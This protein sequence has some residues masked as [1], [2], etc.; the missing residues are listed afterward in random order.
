MAPAACRYN[1]SAMPPLGAH[2]SVA[3]GLARAF[4]RGEDLGCEAIQIFVKN[5]SQWRAAPLD[6][7]AAAQ[8]RS[9]HAA[10]P[11]GPVLAHGSYLVNLAATDE[12]VLGRSREA[13]GDELDRCA[14]LGVAG[15]VVHPGAHLGA[16]EEAGLGRIAESLRAVF[17]A[18][19]R[20]PVPVLLENTAGQGTVLGYRLEQLVAILE[21]AGGL[22]LGVALDTCHAF[23]AG[24][25]VHEEAGLG[26]FLA[27][28]EE[29]F[30]IGR[31]G[32]FH[33]NDSQ[34]PFASRRD[35]H[36]NVGRGAI[37]AEAF[38][39][40]VADPRLAAVPMVLE[41]PGGDEA[42]RW[43]LELLRG[44]SAGESGGSAS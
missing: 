25:P 9:A 30:G 39:R 44:G 2:V 36:A 27:E 21:Q 15:L 14:E 23:A 26:E 5:P 32:C 19:P 33:L 12:T 1:R 40:L 4:A 35:R 11:I 18:R 42:Y 10:S 24:Y 37:G 29:R 41:T 3:G 28:V 38:A 20:C 43:E 13:L 7:A 17:A 8:F 22:P 6:P 34:R 31:V 16:G